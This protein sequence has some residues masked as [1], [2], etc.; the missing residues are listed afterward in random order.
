MIEWCNSCGG[1][2]KHVRDCSIHDRCTRGVVSDKVR[3]CERC[4]DYQTKWEWISTAR[5]ARDTIQHL[6]PKLPPALAGVCAIPRSGMIPASILST[7]L[8]LPLLTLDDEPR[9][10]G[11]GVRGRDVQ[12]R[13]DPSAPILVIDDTVYSGHAMHEAKRKLAGRKAVYAAT[14]VRPEALNSVNVFGLHLPAPHILEWNLF[15]NGPFGGYSQDPQLRG[16]VAIDFDGILCLDEQTSLPLYTPRRL[17]IPAIITGR[18]EI[19]RRASL[20]YLARWGMSCRELL[21]RPDDVGEDWRSIARWKGEQYA[22]GPWSLYVESDPQQAR[23]ICDTARKPVACPQTEE[24]HQW[25][26]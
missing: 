9:E 1:D 21:M 5:L 13:V 16:G 11:H 6:L 19:H 7:L 17:A 14:Y 4:N 24:L 8:N 26:G 10:V 23:L 2:R 20:D 25:T 18:G 22:A 3:S 15:N 12:M